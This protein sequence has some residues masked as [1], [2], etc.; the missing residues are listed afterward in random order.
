MVYLIVLLS[1]AAFGAGPNVV[2]LMADDLGWG[3]LRCYNKESL[4]DTPHLDAMAAGGVRFERFYS[5]SAVC[6]PTRASCLTGRNPERM[7]IHHA[8]NGHLPTEEI[9][10][11]ELLKEKGYR[12]GHFGKW[13][14]GTLT[15]TVQDAN[16]GGPRG[17]EHYAPPWEHGFEVCFSTE[18]KVPTWDPLFVPGKPESRGKWW[19][20]AAK[21]DRQDYGTRYWNEKGEE[22]TENLEG[23]DS[24]LVMD[25]ALGFIEGAV[26]EEKPFFAVVWFHAPHLPVVTG[27][28]YAE[29]Y[30]QEEGFERSYYG[31]VTALDEQV[32]RLRGELRRLGVGEDTMVWFC[33][34][35]GP[36]GGAKDPGQ[37]NGLKGRKRDLWEGG[38]R[39]PG[40]VEWPDGLGTEGRVVTAPAV[41]SDYLPTVLA[42]TGIAYPSERRLD[43]VDL[44]PLL[45]G[46]KKERGKGIGFTFAGQAAWMEGDWKAVRPRKGQGWELYRIDEDAGEKVDQAKEHPELL[47]PLVSSHGV[48]EAGCVASEKG[49]DYEK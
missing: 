11:A 48:W 20:P 17:V 46:E 18:S 33:A 6:S 15:K 19:T 41:T 16:R 34:D 47:A 29:R 27:G 36:E 37:T 35:N 12:T 2:L 40:M 8:N 30:A 13:H 26:K 24:M 4:I 25:R 44:M 5:A 42:V 21:E 1:S 23:D 45:K 43:G 10:L 28:K 49:A 9:T 14:L 7:G 31:C 32:G 22:V 38:I 39:V 3:D